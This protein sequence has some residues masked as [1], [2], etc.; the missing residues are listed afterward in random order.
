MDITA[1]I[2]FTLQRADKPTC[3][4]FGKPY[5]SIELL[6]SDGIRMAWYGGDWKEAKEKACDMVSSLM[7][8]ASYEAKVE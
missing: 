4:K 5:G 2:T 3:D 6:D 8:A 1:T 7:D